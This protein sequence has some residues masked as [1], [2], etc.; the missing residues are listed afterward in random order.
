M[1]FKGIRRAPIFVFYITGKVFSILEL[2]LFEWEKKPSKRFNFTVNFLFSVMISP[3]LIIT[4][5]T[6]IYD[7]WNSIWHNGRKELAQVKYSLDIWNRRLSWCTKL[8]LCPLVICGIPRII[9]KSCKS[10]Y[11]RSH[12]YCLSTCMNYLAKVQVY[13][14]C[15]INGR[16]ST[17]NFLQY[18][19][20]IELWTKMIK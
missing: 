7:F 13:S 14:T 11:L 4:F 18:I 1:M 19:H 5:I 6:N 9:S 12:S 20:Q 15:T 8:R 17:R 16:I 10:S 2:L 3:S